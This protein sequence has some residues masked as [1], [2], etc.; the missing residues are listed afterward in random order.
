MSQASAGNDTIAAIATPA[1]K[2]AVGIVRLS[3]PAARSIGE[4]ITARKLRPRQADYATF[5]DAT[6]Q[7]ID[8]GLVLFFPNP[9]SYTGEDIVEL[10]CHG[11]PLILRALVE[12]ALT[13]GARQARP[14]EFTERAFLNDKLDLLQAEAV[15]DLIESNSMLA[16]KNASRSLQGRFSSD[17][18]AVLTQLIDLRV[19]V[20]SAL[21]FP[22][23]ELDF[24][25]DG[26]LLDGLTSCMNTIEALLARARQGQRLREGRRIVIAGRPNVGKSSLLNQLTGFA[27]AIVSEVSGTTRDLVER[28]VVLGGVVAQLVDTAGIRHTD[29]PVESEGV[30]RTRQALSGADII[31]H[32]CEH[33]SLADNSEPLFELHDGVEQV[34]VYNKIDLAG[35]PAGIE[36][37][38]PPAVYL[39]AKTGSGID[40]LIDQ[41]G[42]LLGVADGTENLLLARDRHIGA[43]HRAR[44]SVADS[45]RQLQTGGAGELLAEDLRTAQTALSELKGEFL[46]DDLL[47]EIF[48]RFCIGK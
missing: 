1:G 20:E 25:N 32:V 27:T 36:P 9:T 24:L 33:G 4:H 22:E 39:S 46:P 5:Y 35:R 19:F 14:G 28:E 13:L 11:S 26:K 16:A 38:N 29:D 8:A 45:L 6:G 47:G 21:D 44:D 42:A 18:D 41:I 15:A 31:L 34:T 30:A 23:E 37:G 10:Q 2:G 43:M 40:L 3:G 12:R 7:A 48:S 17:V